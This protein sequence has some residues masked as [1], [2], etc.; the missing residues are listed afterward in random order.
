MIV[1]YVKENKM[2]MY[3]ETSLGGRQVDLDDPENYPPYWKHMESYELWTMA[4]KEAGKSLFYMQFLDLEIDWGSQEKR[5]HHLCRELVC[6]RVDSIEDTMEA[7]LK[8]M[9]WLFRFQDEVENQ[10]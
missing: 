10:C 5:V 4:W 8:V 2:D 6:L 3:Q 7:R 9:K 1:G